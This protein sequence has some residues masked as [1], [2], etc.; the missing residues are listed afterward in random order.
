MKQ[1]NDKSG[2]DFDS[3]FINKFFACGLFL[4][5][6]MIRIKSSIK[7]GLEFA[8]NFRLCTERLGLGWKQIS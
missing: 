3:Y 4:L 2:I 7:Y 1:K 5:Q 8:D 6:I